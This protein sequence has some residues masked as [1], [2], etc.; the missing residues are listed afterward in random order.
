MSVR[1]GLQAAP[2]ARCG[3]CT[4]SYTHLDVYKRQTVASRKSPR[5][6]IRSVPAMICTHRVWALR[7]EMLPTSVGAEVPDFG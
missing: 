1:T 3:T 6:P 4:V 5:P 7:F 2:P